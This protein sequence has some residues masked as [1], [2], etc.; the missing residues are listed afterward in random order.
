ML[1]HS[2]FCELFLLN[3]TYSFIVYN[4]EYLRTAKLQHRLQLSMKK[5]SKNHFLSYMRYLLA[6]FGGIYRKVL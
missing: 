3:R 4:K 2:R 5:R 1:R 6:S